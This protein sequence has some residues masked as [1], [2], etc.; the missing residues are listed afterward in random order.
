MLMATR[1]TWFGQSQQATPVRPWSLRPIDQSRRYG[2]EFA[3]YYSPR[4][5]ITLD[6]DFSLSH[7]QFRDDDPAQA[8]RET[9]RDFA[10]F[11]CQ[12][13][14]PPQAS[15]REAL[16][17]ISLDLTKAELAEWA[18]QPDGATHHE[19]LLPATIITTYGRVEVLEQG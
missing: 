4:N 18:W 16:L 10:G 6:A 5:W 1:S 11:W 17:R 8:S 14:A 19:W 15:G 3:N 7:A 2:I 12:A 9:R 13:T